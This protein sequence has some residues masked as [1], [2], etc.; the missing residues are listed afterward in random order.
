MS[1]SRGTCCWRRCDTFPA[2]MEPRC[3]VPRL[4]RAPPCEHA[5]LGCRAMAVSPRVTGAAGVWLTRH[6][7]HGQPLPQCALPFSFSFPPTRQ[8]PRAP[9]RVHASTWTAVRSLR[10]RL[11]QGAHARS[12]TSPHTTLPQTTRPRLCSRPPSSSSSCSWG[13][14]SSA[15]TT[16]SSRRANTQP[17]LTATIPP[18]PPRRRLPPPR[19]PRLHPRVAPATRPTRLSPDGRGAL[20]FAHKNQRKACLQGLPPLAHY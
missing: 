18:P 15:R 13:A 7:Q 12:P 1:R 5:C 11:L 20:W 17:Q 8:P 14:C 3:C 19:R 6:I 4:Q 10:R 16:T 9:S 2:A